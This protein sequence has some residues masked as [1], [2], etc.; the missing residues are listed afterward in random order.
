MYITNNVKNNITKLFRSNNAGIYDYD[1]SGNLEANLSWST[2]LNGNTVNNRN[3]ALFIYGMAL[4]TASDMFAHSSYDSNG[5]YINHDSGADDIYEVENRYK[6]AEVMASYMIANIKRFR[7]GSI[8]DYYNVAN[9]TV[10]DGSFT[11]GRFAT[12]AK[13][14]D[15]S[16]YISIKMSLM[17]WL[18]KY[19]EGGV[20][21]EKIILL[22]YN[23]GYNRH[24][25][26]W[27]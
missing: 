11:L 7:S 10:Y 12:Y 4:H 15:E 3:K 16:Y 1:S 22:L 8:S 5:N 24:M 18:T 25:L 6:C 13:E 19:E 14:I 27:K 9:S 20:S 23:F 26:V 2:V 21:I 17:Q